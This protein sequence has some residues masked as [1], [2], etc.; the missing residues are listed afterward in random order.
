ML[1]SEAAEPVFARH[2][3]FQPRYG[4]FRKAYLT[5]E[6]DLRGF[7]RRD[8]TVRLGVG[9]N[10]VRAIRF[11]GLAAK[12]IQEEPRSAN[13][14]SPD[15]GPTELGRALFGEQGWDTY[16][17]DPGTLWLLHWLI[18]APPCLIPVWW[19]AFHDFQAVE[20]TG[21]DLAEAVASRVEEVPN[22]ETPSL[23]SIKKD[24]DIL[25]RAYDPSL[26]SRP[27]D[28]DGQIECPLR[29]LNL[30]EN[31]QSDGRYRFRMGP[32]ATL[33]SEIVTYAA[34]D[35]ISR[36]RTGEGTMPLSRLAYDP[37]SPGRAF[38]LSET[39]L[40]IALEPTVEQTRQV[41]LTNRTG[42][43]HLAWSGDP[44]AT[45]IAVL[46][47]YYYRVWHGPDVDVSLLLQTA[48]EKVQ[49]RS[50]AEILL[51]VDEPQPMVAARH[52]AR[53]DILRVF[54]RRYVDGSAEIE[55]PGPFSSYDGEALMVMDDSDALPRKLRSQT[56]GKPV[57]AALPKDLSDL[58][59]VAREI[60]VVKIALEDPAARGDRL[61]RREL[62]ERLGR[63]RRLLEHALVAA[64][65][66]DSCRWV[67]LK[68][69]GGGAMP[70]TPGRGSTALS[71]A[72]D[73]A[74]PD[75]PLV[76][77]EML[78]RNSLTSQGTGARR[79]LLEA[80]VECSDQ[81]LLGFEGYGPEVAMYKAV[82]ETTGLHRRDDP[83]QTMAFRSPT[84]ETW[85]SAW[86]IM[87][88]EFRRAEN[89]RIDLTDLHAV[90]RSPPVGMKA[91][92]IPVFVLAG[93]LAHR[94]QVAV[95]EAGFARPLTPELAERTA[96]R[97]GQFSIGSPPDSEAAD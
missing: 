91:G 31:L 21:S 33:P 22:W 29:E 60:A 15:I 12:I 65:G 52:S 7:G 17:E 49:D 68:E 16:V 48:Q 13:R 3:S 71:D 45:A 32:K 1:L 90:L 74:Y 43:S 69:G 14:R 66:S 40:A 28:D 26:R 62:R 9:K 37:G 23:S 35:Y 39:D 11:W 51:S 84:D 44:A 41:S 18:L 86:E 61:A 57:V 89:E 54:S 97:P 92:V 5:A 50:L 36:I 8:A 25:F 72:A 2:E 19:I 6:R 76:R 93:L 78:N 27:S 67:L 30:I 63:A 34:L 75:T 58:E 79:K 42:F 70:L 88:E 94:D 80:M 55:P 85:E 20:F 53:H 87:T 83:D 59:A 24:V 47:E 64:F 73:E 46:E 81:P 95:Y 4:W 77:N 56:E 82:L 96:S 10:M 38:K